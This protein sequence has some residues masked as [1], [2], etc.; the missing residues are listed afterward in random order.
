MEK[1]W[2][3]TCVALL[4]MTGL[5]TLEI[6][7]WNESQERVLEQKMLG[8]LETL[9]VLEGGTFVVKL[10]W[11]ED[12]GAMTESRVEPTG[13]RI[14]RRQQ[15]VEPVRPVSYDKSPPSKFFP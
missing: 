10:P 2:L 11:A 7:L 1:M 9:K 14:E 5:R 15:G 6:D 8:Y 4:H 13:F 3:S 12:N